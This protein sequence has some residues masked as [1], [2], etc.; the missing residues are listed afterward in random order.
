MKIKKCRF[1]NS[2][3]LSV[4]LDLG[5]TPPADQFLKT[6]QKVNLAKKYPLKVALCSECGLVQL[7]YTCPGEILYQQDYPYESDITS[8][9]RNH[10]KNFAQDL[11]KRFRLSQNDLVV[12]IGSN[13][14]ELLSNFSRN[15][16]KVCGI[17]P[18]K[19]IA[20]KAIKSGIPTITEFFNESILKT[21]L[22]KKI[23]PR[24]ITGTN[25]FAHIEDINGSLRVIKEILVS[26]GI[27]IIEAP[28]LHNLI[29]GLEYDTIYHEHLTYLSIKPLKKLFSRHGMEIFDIQFKDIHGGSFR[30]FIQHKNGSQKISKKILAM[31]KTEKKKKI[32]DFKNLELFSKKVKTHKSDLIE[33]LKNLK[34]EGKK[35]AGIG[36]PAKGMTLINYC[37]I[38]T[39]FLEFVTEVS[40]LKINKYCPGTNLKILRDYE[41]TKQK[42]DYAIIFPWNF[43]NEIMKNLNE[44]EKNG[45]KF[46]IP[47]PKIQIINEK[48]GA[49]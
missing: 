48:K 29:S 34:N 40:K 33:L 36:A 44:F 35:I 41:L 7:N 46:I 28:Y 30:V 1:C 3:K 39:N 37:G 27:F 19:N 45:G 6:P 15:G 5:K 20:K 38:D 31:E 4:F 43:K 24:I 2:Q 49:L 9:G 11:I 32:H 21:L 23:F 14:G 25:V 22:K 26:N 10:W 17:D 18:A 47:F 12:D 16:I 8:E 13:V 42:I